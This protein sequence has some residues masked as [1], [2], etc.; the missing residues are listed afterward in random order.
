M[1]LAGEESDSVELLGERFPFAAGFTPDS[2]LRTENGRAEGEELNGRE[3]SF[4]FDW[5]AFLVAS[6]LFSEAEG[7]EDGGP[8]PSFDP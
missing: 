3:E 7:D 5:K 1:E 6:R 8:P 2:S 4:Y